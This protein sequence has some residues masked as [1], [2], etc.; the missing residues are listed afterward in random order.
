MINFLLDGSQMADQV[1]HVCLK[2]HFKE[3]VC[4]TCFYVFIVKR[5]LGTL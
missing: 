1:I 3:N 4:L 5:P 2:T